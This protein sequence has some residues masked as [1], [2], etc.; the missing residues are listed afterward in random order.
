MCHRNLWIIIIRTDTKNDY[1]YEA[2]EKMFDLRLEKYLLFL[3]SK[4]E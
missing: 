4:V 3:L 1:N 2:T